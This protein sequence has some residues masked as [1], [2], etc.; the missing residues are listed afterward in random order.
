M[1]E[2]VWGRGP[3]E[4]RGLGERL[5]K[6][7]RRLFSDGIL[8]LGNEV[9]CDIAKGKDHFPRKGR[10]D[11]EGRG[12]RFFMS[13]RE[14]YYVV[15]TKG[16]L[17]QAQKVLKGDSENMSPADG[18]REPTGREGEKGGTT[19]STFSDAQEG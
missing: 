13:E 5:E 4:R 14:G 10:T 11:F 12:G 2:S 3:E 19:K 7:G 1:K 9:G 16:Y 8:L 15:L 18:G 6:G 17:V